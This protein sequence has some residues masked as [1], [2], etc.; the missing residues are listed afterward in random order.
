VLSSSN[1]S[2]PSF[3]AESAW[4]GSREHSRDGKNQGTY[5]GATQW[6]AVAAVAALRGAG[7]GGGS[8]S[9]RVA[10]FGHALP[11]LASTRPV[12]IK[13]HCYLCQ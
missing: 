12:V 13:D 2:T 11:D 8:K 1:P 5:L 9:V 7:G 3:A 4:L 10:T 6:A